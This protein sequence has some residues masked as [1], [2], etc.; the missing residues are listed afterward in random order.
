MNTKK[1]KLLISILSLIITSLIIFFILIVSGS[2]NILPEKKEPV[3]EPTE[4]VVE[5]DKE[6]EKLKQYKVDWQAN[7]KINPDY[8]G[9]ILFDSG[10]LRVSFVQA[11]SVYKE[12]GTMYSFYTENGSL[13]SNPEGYTGNDVYI[14]TYWKTGAYDYNDNGG[15]TFMDY[16]NELS[17]QNIVIYGHH[18]SVWNDETRS[19]AFTPL[20]KLLEE[21]NYSA[22]KNVTLIL[23]DEIRK[24]EVAAVYNFDATD[25]YYYDNMQ[26]WRTSYNYDDYTDTID[27]E[28]YSKYLQAV[29]EHQLYNTGVKLD[30]SDKTLTLQTCISGH[31]GELFEIIVL[32]QV[33]VEPY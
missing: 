7:K 4:V 25:D 18:F 14:W 5:P 1:K 17:D 2:I 16:R 27:N 20:E 12:D 13:V 21:E 19:K 23:G 8:I 6:A 15:S 33:S 30:T 10:L 22:N 29:R 32:K 24:Y 9:D 28:Y 3:P 26:Y 31:T 11:K